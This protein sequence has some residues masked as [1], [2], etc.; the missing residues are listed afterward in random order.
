M[1]GEI[2]GSVDRQLRA[3]A[4]GILGRRDGVSN[5]EQKRDEFIAGVEKSSE[6]LK[7]EVETK[8]RK[9]LVHARETSPYYRNLWY[10][11]GLATSLN[12]ATSDFQQIPYLTKDIIRDHAKEMISEKFNK[13]SL[14][15][16]LTSGTTRAR[17]PFYRNHECTVS[18]VGRQWGIL[19]LCGYKPGM[20]RALVWGVHSDL[21]QSNSRKNLKQWFR[22]Y[23]TSQV[24]LGCKVMNEQDMYGFHQRLQKYR[25][26]ILYGYSTAMVR[27]GRYIQDMKLSPIRVKKIFTTAERLT[28]RDRMFL[29]EAFAGEVFNLY[30]TREYGCIGFE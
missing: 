24:A 14:D 15:E 7:I 5:W 13:E 25:P 2:L 4:Y 30:C 19:G 23:A 22:E 28:S 26:D 17:T 1:F 6:E 9:L 3:I 20:R 16:D 21:L 29:Q 8:L 10:Q 18:R 27:F 12:I 11:H